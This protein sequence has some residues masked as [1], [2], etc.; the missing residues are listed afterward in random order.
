MVGSL[1]A[2]TYLIV[3]LDKLVHVATAEITIALGF[4]HTCFPN[5]MLRLFVIVVQIEKFGCTVRLP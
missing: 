1:A 5:S 4:L 2:V 3:N